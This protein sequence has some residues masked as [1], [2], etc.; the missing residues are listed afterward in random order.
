MN[1][2]ELYRALDARIPPSLSADWDRDGLQVCAEPDREVSRVLCTLDVTDDVVDCAIHGGYDVILSHHPLMFAP[3][4]ALTDATPVARRAMRLCRAGIASMSFHTRAD[5]MDGGVNDLLCK[6]LGLSDVTPFGEEGEVY[7]RVGV[8]D[9]PMSTAELSAF[10]CAALGTPCVTVSDSKRAVMRLAVCG[11]EGK[12]FIP[13]AV[14]VGADAY[15]A[16]RLGYHALIEGES[17]GI[18]LLEAG[19]YYTERQIAGK[20]ARMVKELC[21]ADCTVYDTPSLTVY[22]KSL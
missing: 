17:L 10:L 21:D 8:F 18:T 7:G 3:L 13:A 12:D 1:I 20:F 14:A 16:G 15:L 22:T 6:K 11:G 2:K 4:T 9:C 5:A 19:H